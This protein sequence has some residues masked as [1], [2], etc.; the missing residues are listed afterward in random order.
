VPCYPGYF[1]W[2]PPTQSSICRQAAVITA[3]DVPPSP[4][5]PYSYLWMEVQAESET[6]NAPA[7]LV[8]YVVY[9]FFVSKDGGAEQMPCG[10]YD[11]LS[12]CYFMA[13]E[14]GT[15]TLRV[16]VKNEASPNDYDNAAERTVEV[17]K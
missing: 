12:E 5:P 3:F 2:K 4:T 10:G 17:T 14:P 11:Y 9:R 8:D 15:Y 13:T 1:C 16:E 7:G 6:P